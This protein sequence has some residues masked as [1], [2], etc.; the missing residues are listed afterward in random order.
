[1]QNYYPRV[2]KTPMELDKLIKN[3]EEKGK[4]MAF[5]KKLGRKLSY[6]L[7]AILIIVGPILMI[8]AYEAHVINITAHICN[9]SETRTP[10]Y[11]KTHEEVT[12]P[13]LPQTVGC[14]TVETF[15]E[16]FD[17]LDS[18][19]NNMREKLAS[20][21]LAM[22]LNIANFGIGGYIA[23]TC[24][25][26]GKT[27]DQL[28]SEADALVCDPSAKKKDMEDIKN[29]LDCLNNLHVLRYCAPSALRLDKFSSISSEV[30]LMTSEGE[31]IETQAPA[32]GEEPIQIT[33]PSEETPVEEIPGEETPVEEQ[34]EEES[35][36][37]E[38][39]SEESE[40]VPEEQ[41]PT[42]ETPVEET[43]LT[44][45]STPE[46]IIETNTTTNE[47]TPPTE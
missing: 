11:W 26:G 38:T 23:D 7:F 39:P 22:K 46:P 27:I 35:P 9:Y 16:A 30:L 17:I 20:H 1:M 10:G 33:A 45:E 44:P 21:L 41:T 8:S 40:P 43:T 15:E 13:L 3:E 37:E 4:K 12:T 25:G 47:T 36:E 19:A 24:G 31:L 32:E 18:S 14:E 29:I 6:L 28:V 42:E 5:L 2:V 34:P